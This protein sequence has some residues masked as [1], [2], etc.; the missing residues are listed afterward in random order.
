[1]HSDSS[2]AGPSYSDLA[3]ANITLKFAPSGGKSVV[4]SE[5]FDNQGDSFQK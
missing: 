1:M 3:Q 4:S 5:K 2:G